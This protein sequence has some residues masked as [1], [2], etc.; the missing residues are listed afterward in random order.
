MGQVGLL[1]E[2]IKQLSLGPPCTVWPEREGPVVLASLSRH[3]L[4]ILF[5]TGWV[6]RQPRGQN[7][8]PWWAGEEGSGN[9]EL[10][11]VQYADLQAASGPGQMW[12]PSGGLEAPE[13]LEGRKQT[14]PGPG[15]WD[16]E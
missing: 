10:S 9:R 1:F 5:L 3:S 12:M 16:V 11:G 14:A 7:G 15:C 8:P 6:G 13:T 4:G 2:E